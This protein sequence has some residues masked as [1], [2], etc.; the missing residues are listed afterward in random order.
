M[1][2][3]CIVEV[4]GGGYPRGG[5]HLLLLV[6]LAEY[7]D[8]KGD[9][10]YPS[11]DSLARRMRCLPR[12]VQKLMRDLESD[13]VVEPVGPASGGR[14]GSTRRWRLNMQKIATPVLRD[15]P[16]L[17]DTPV[18]TDTPVV[19]DTGV[20]EDAEGCP[21]GRR[22]L[23]Y[24]TPEPSLTVIEPMT[25]PAAPDAGA[26]IRPEGLGATDPKATIW[27]LGVDLLVKH[28]SSESAARSFLARFA[29]QDERKLAETIGYLA[30]NS[31]VEPRAY[32]AAAMKP[33]QREFVG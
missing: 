17:Q 19:A 33:K 32:I 8:D 1:S 16:V 2:I 22:P 4:L 12:Q 24:R 31:K 3:R 28:G 13:G 14:P 11:I 5:S 26:S 18:P 7:A 9:S 6:I 21:T 23:S 10:I 27:R 20:L 15:T 25:P 29:K 30:A